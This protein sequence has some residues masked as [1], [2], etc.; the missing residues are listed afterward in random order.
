M[1]R[2]ILALAVTCNAFRG[3][4]RNRLTLRTQPAAAVDVDAIK[5]AVAPSELSASSQ[6]IYSW[7]GLALGLSPRG[8]FHASRG[9]RGVAS[10][11]RSRQNTS[12]RAPGCNNR[13]VAWVPRA[14]AVPPP[15]REWLKRPYD[16]DPAVR[17]LPPSRAL[18]RSLLPPRRLA[19][20]A[21]VHPRGRRRTASDGRGVPLRAPAV[22][23]LAPTGQIAPSAALPCPRRR[24]ASEKPPPGRERWPRTSL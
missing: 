12:A 21:A 14:L 11:A 22:L 10:E 8:N 7:T 4:V 2:L 23:A 13:P 5:N 19:R 3:P 16:C 17:K 18:A 15:R 1:S 20:G 9:L 6:A 24:V